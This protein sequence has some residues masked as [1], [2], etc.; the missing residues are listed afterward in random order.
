MEVSIGAVRY[1]RK[2]YRSLICHYSHVTFTE[3][4][5]PGMALPRAMERIEKN[6]ELV[7]KMGRMK[8]SVE[9]QLAGLL[10]V[11]EEQQQLLKLA[12]IGETHPTVA[13]H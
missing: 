8:G 5:V 1:S 3:P 7:A 10:S 2:L 12:F 13:T 6:L 9:A 11:C 4:V